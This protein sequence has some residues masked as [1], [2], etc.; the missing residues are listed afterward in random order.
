MT[1]PNIIDCRALDHAF[2]TG[3]AR[4]QVLFGVDLSI[5]R[6]EFVVLK[7]ASGSGKTTLLTLLACLRQIQGGTVEVLGNR[8]DGAPAKRLVEVRRRLGFIFQSHNL[9]PA[10][11]AMQNV[12]MGLELH[13]GQAMENWQDRAAH[14]L[15]SLGLGARLDYLPA[16]LSGGQKQRVA[17]ARALVGNP[18]IVFA[19][20][21]T[22]A[23][24]ADSARRVIEILKELG[25]RRGTTSLVVTHD[26]R[27]LDCADRIVTLDSG[28]VIPWIGK[29]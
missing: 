3:E 19:D 22:A 21:P 10:L 14:I 6:G 18:E 29:P 16:K 23:L 26:Q 5:A 28:R 2:G 17:I 4:A 25:R 8:L 1:A 27:L 12:R 9:H 15:T 7:G 20:E 11:S 13:G 24:D